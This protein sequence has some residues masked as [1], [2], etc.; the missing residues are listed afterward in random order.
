ML[1]DSL[2]NFVVFVIVTIKQKIDWEEKQEYL[3][4]AFYSDNSIFWSPKFFN[5]K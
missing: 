3:F 5:V 2:D 1:F 4:L